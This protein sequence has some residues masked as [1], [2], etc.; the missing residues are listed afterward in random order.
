METMLYH[1]DCLEILPT[2]EARSVDAV[3]TDPPYP[4][5]KRKYGYWTVKEWFKMMRSVVSECKRI[6]KPSGSA[7]FI[8][9]PNYEHVGV[10]R[11]W[12]WDFMAWSCRKWNMV[13]DVWWWNFTAP[14]V[15][16]GVHRDRGLLKGS[17]KACVWLGAPDCHRNQDEVLWKSQYTEHAQRLSN[18]LHRHP[19]GMTVRRKRIQ[20]TVI[21]RG[22]SVPFNVLR[23]DAD[24]PAVG[25]VTMEITGEQLAGMMARI[26]KRGGCW[27]WTG[28]CTRSS[29]GEQYPCVRIGGKTHTVRRVLYEYYKGTMTKRTTMSC[30]NELCVNPEHVVL[31]SA[32]TGAER[33]RKHRLRRMSGLRAVRVL[34]QRCGFRLERVGP[35]RYVVERVA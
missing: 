25:G 32:A 4:E 9:Q 26:E 35:G 7:V 24:A 29:R 13:Q 8:L 30:G 23:A 34:A 28:G 19:S 1:G 5:I 21:E 11:P 27:V 18:K 15:G 31:S 17:L 33:A 16:R 10:V 20:D 3:V 22:G 12:L 14:P 2:L 6:L